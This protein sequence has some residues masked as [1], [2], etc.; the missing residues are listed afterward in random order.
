[1]TFA[2]PAELCEEGIFRQA[3]NWGIRKWR[4]LIQR[5]L[6]CKSSGFRREVASD[7]GI[8]V[9]S[10]FIN[11][12]KRYRVT[13][14]KKGSILTLVIATTL[15]TGCAS[16]STGPNASKDGDSSSGESLC[17][18]HASFID[19]YEGLI[20]AD[21]R[22]FPAHHGSIFGTTDTMLEVGEP[23]PAPPFTLQSRI[24]FVAN[25]SFAQQ[26]FSSSLRQAMIDY[27]NG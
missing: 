11:K 9:L 26:C 25:S 7:S 21:G 5:Y 27:V 16:S 15:L 20:G 4:L 17:T 13:T 22:F 6:I 18:K 12:R 14:F 2:P 1:L 8:S 23:E 3:R 24:E 19:M 10:Q